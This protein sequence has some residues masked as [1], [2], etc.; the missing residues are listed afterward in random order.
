MTPDP[1]TAAFLIFFMLAEFGRGARHGTWTNIFQELL[2]HITTVHLA[3]CD[4]TNGN[5][6]GWHDLFID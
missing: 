4:T 6:L 1:I 2:Q 5:F 3:G